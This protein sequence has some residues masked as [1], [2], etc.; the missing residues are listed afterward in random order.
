MRVSAKQN[1]SKYRGFYKQHNEAFLITNCDFFR[2]SGII[3]SMSE[4]PRI[5][6]FFIKI[7]TFLDLFAWF[8]WNPTLYAF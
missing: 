4:S 3:L 7:G 6:T 8:R 2:L 5:V 1:A